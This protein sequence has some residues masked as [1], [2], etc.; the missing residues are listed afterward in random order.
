MES[1]SL[2]LFFVTL[3]CYS[4]SAAANVSRSFTF[5]TLFNNIIVITITVIKYVIHLR[6]VKDL[7]IVAVKCTGLVTQN[8]RI[9]AK[10]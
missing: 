1:L 5:H 9:K 10:K 4:K 2:T 8:V 3:Q 6:S 7:N